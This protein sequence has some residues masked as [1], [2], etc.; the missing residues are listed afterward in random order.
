ME[1]RSLALSLLLMSFLVAIYLIYG[2]W[3]PAP[4]LSNI[5]GAVAALFLSIG[6]AGI[7]SLAGL[8]YHYPVIDDALA[9][10]DRSLGIDLPAI[11]SWFAD[12]PAL[13]KLLDVAYQSSFLQLLGLVVLLPLLRRTDK[14][15][16]LV[17]VCSLA[18]VTSTTISIFWPAT[19]AFA[20]F[21]YSNDILGKLPLNAGTYHLAKFEYYRNAAAPVLSFASLQGVVTFPSFH[22]CLALMTIFAVIGTG[23]LFWIVA[24]WNALVLISTLPIGGHYVIDLAGG[25]LLW[26]V[27]VALAAMLG[28]WSAREPVSGDRLVA[29]E[30][31]IAT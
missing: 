12:H 18:I 20:Y 9:E 8:R 26:L 28:R 27:C 19:G 2:T 4:V 22:C 16:E 13:S 1:I 17:F 3:R 21:D 24:S 5:G 10:S 15:W 31:G 14:L 30:A 25:G 7:I 6:M 23:W 11:I 29:A